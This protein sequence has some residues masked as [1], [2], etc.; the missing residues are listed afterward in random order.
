MADVTRSASASMDASTGMF[1]V[2]ITGLIAGEDLDLVSAC[3]IKTSDGKVY[4]AD[5]SAA[6]ELA[7]FVGMTPRAAKSGQAITLYSLGARF[8]YGTSLSPGAKLYLSATTGGIADAASL[9]GTLPLGVVLNSTD[10][11]ITTA[12]GS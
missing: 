4:M 6:D 12:Q 9:G 3:Y 7:E 2:Q 10:I 1:A 5:G 11:L 8:R